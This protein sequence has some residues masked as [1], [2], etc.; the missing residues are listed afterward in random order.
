MLKRRVKRKVFKPKDVIEIYDDNLTDDRYQGM[1]HNLPPLINHVGIYFLQ[2]NLTLPQAQ[3][4][5]QHYEKLEWK[6]VTGKPQ[7][8]WKVLAKDWI[9]NIIQNAKLLERREAKRKVFPDT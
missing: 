2:Q 3:C 7:K 9:Y 6:T 4:F 8:N 1:G 5:Y